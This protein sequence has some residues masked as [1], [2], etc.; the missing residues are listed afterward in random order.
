MLT[1]EAMQRFVVDSITTLLSLEIN[2]LRM[3]EVGICLLLKFLLQEHGIGTI[4]EAA[5]VLIIVMMY[6]LSGIQVKLQLLDTITELQFSE[7][8]D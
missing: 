5:A 4:K 8:T 7:L 3:V 1:Q 6:Q 2:S